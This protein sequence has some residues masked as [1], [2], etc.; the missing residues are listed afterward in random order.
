MANNNKMSYV[1]DHPLSA[2]ISLGKSAWFTGQVKMVK[3]AL[4]L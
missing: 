4:D 2:V 1:M 3:L